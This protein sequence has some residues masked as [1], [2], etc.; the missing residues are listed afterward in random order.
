MLKAN[1]VD[2][3]MRVLVS[4]MELM[5]SMGRHTNVISLQGVCSQGANHVDSE[6]RVLVSE[7]ELMKSMGRHT[8]VIS[9]QG[10]CSQG[11][12]L[13]VI[14]EFCAKGNLRDYLRTH[15]MTAV[16]ATYGED[17]YET[18]ITSSHRGD[19]DMLPLGYKNLSFAYQTAR[20]MEYLANKR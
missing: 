8:N 20:G 5:K 14:V 18:P 15:R 7:M 4:E 13:Y 12:P 19:E 11:G 10:V 2:S 17:G 3:E 16:N 6:M 1:H 9:L